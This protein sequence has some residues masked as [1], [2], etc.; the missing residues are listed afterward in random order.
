[1]INP[2]LLKIIM[3]VGQPKEVKIMYTCKYFTIKELVS[4]SVYDF[5]KSRYGELFIWKCPKCKRKYY[6]DY[7]FF[8]NDDMQRGIV[9]VDSSAN[10]LKWWYILLTI[11]LIGIVL[12]YILVW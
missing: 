5:Y 4:K 6:I 11:A 9:E 3:E 8:I 10:Q 2:K 1:M 7:C 12:A